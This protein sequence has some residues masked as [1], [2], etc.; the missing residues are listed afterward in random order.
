MK[1]TIKLSLNYEGDDEVEVDRSL[2]ANTDQ[3]GQGV[4][5]GWTG[6]PDVSAP[7]SDHRPNTQTTMIILMNTAT[8]PIRTITVIT[9]SFQREK[10]T[11][12]TDGVL[13]QGVSK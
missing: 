3:G 6:R 10:S 13:I 7:T 9:T 1:E 2:V 5:S 8:I 4:G 12:T 11:K